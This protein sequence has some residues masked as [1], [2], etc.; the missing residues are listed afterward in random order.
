MDND[1]LT[2]TVIHPTVTAETLGLNFIEPFFGESHCGN[3]SL[4]MQ[5]CL[6]G[7]L[8]YLGPETGPRLHEI[9]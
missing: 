1:L 7:E 9:L 8:G 3:C 4:H 5:F 6:T 2:F